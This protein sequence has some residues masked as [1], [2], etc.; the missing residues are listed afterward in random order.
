MDVESETD[1]ETLG[2]MKINS[3]RLYLAP[4]LGLG[5]SGAVLIPIC[6]NSISK[7]RADNEQ[8]YEH[9]SRPRA[10]EIHPRPAISR[11]FLT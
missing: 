11:I 3:D 5:L 6:C 8:D 4:T 10:A 7:D 9:R 1:T 2:K